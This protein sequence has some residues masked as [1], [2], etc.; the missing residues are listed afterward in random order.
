MAAAA[1]NAS[2][3]HDGESRIKTFAAW[4]PGTGEELLAAVREALEALLPQNRG[5]I[6]LDGVVWA[7]ERPA[8][9]AVDAAGRAVAVIAAEEEGGSAN[10]AALLAAL[11]AK[12]WVG[13][14]LGLLARAYPEAGLDA[15]AETGPPVVLVAQSRSGDLEL[16]CPAGV[17]LVAWTGVAYGEKRGV[18]LRRVLEATEGLRLKAEGLR[19]GKKEE[20]TTE[21]TP[22][23]DPLP[24]RERGDGRVA[25]ESSR[26]VEQENSR[27]GEIEKNSNSAEIVEVLADGLDEELSAGEEAELRRSLDLD[28]LT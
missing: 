28:Q 10:P 12:R 14:H 11:E 13:E 24:S 27:A 3:P 15:G 17:E 1:N 25:A 23:P 7:A 4:S 9:L 19:N 26:A 22:S 16:I 2:A 21:T 6:E 18:M 20:T 8:L 5:V